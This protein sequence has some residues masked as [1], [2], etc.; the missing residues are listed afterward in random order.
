MANIV[1]G[2]EKFLTNLIVPSDKYLFKHS[3]KTASNKFVDKLKQNDQKN[4]I[5][6]VP[7]KL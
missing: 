1:P 6:D 2:N 5:S 4:F 3:A 7:V